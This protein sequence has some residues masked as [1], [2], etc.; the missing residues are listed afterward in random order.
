MVVVN[1]FGDV[2]DATGRIIAGA[3]NGVGGFVDTLTV[4]QSNIA[5]PSKFDDVAHRNTT[6]AVVACSAPLASD[7][8]T[9]LAR[10]A[11][12]ALFR[13]IT[14]AGSSFDGDVVFAV[15]PQSG[16]PWELDLVGRRG[17]FE[18][19]VIESLAVAALEDAVERAVRLARGREGVPGLADTNAG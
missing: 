17:N 6:L 7:Q 13:R 3:R 15:S 1:A 4:L 9:Q 11:G 12:A 18:P 14:P 8:L 2:R 16:T 19:M 10:A 5:S